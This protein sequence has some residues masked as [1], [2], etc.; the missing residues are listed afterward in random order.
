M[1]KASLN[2][3]TTSFICEVF[4]QDNTKTDGSGLTGLTNGSAGLTAYYK[5]SGGSASVAFTL[6]AISTLGTFAGGSTTGAFKEVD[7]T[8]MPGVYELHLPNALFSGA[9]SAVVY[10]QGAANMA[11]LVLEIELTAT[12]N[13]DGTRGGMTALPN[14]NANA[15]GGLP[16]VGGAGDL[17]AIKAKTDLIGL[18]TSRSSLGR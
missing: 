18:G 5:K 11:P 13:Q 1:A 6:S 14:A 17:A 16:I 7:S 9:T 12:N 3:G 8:N 2:T 15:N 10:L 4:V